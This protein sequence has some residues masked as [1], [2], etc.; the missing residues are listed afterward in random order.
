[1]LFHFTCRL[2]DGFHNFQ[3]RNWSYGF[4]FRL[5]E[6]SH[7]PIVLLNIWTLCKFFGRDSH[8]FGIQFLTNLKDDLPS[9]SH[10]FFPLVAK[11]QYNLYGPGGDI[12]NLDSLCTLP[13]NSFYEKAFLVIYFWYAVLLLL[14]LLGV[15][16]GFFSMMTIGR[17]IILCSGTVLKL[18]E[19]VDFAAQQ[20]V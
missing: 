5:L 20:K 2:V 17:A 3:D 19:V 12:N 4:T 18:E 11:C 8:L 6:S 15:I 10:R 13:T 16:C 14:T 7:L 1:M 9:M